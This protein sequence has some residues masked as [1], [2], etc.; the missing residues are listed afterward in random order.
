MF[1]FSNRN[2]RKRCETYSEL[3]IKQQ[4]DVSDVIVNFEHI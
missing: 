1:K 4:N 2:N 3:T